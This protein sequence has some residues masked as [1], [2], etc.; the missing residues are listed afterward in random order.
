MSDTPEPSEAT[1]QFLEDMAATGHP[2]RVDG[3]RILYEIVAVGGPHQ[4]ETITTGV[5]VSE[6]QQWPLSP[7]HW[8]HL[9]ED[10]TFPGTNSDT[11]DCLPGWRRHS[12]DFTFTDTSIP[13]AL[14]WLRHVR[15]QLSMITPLAA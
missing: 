6:V 1:V 15:G 4:S 13:P 14:A 3:A 8:I 11:T 2:A 10:L 9:P 7:P 5:S 12:R